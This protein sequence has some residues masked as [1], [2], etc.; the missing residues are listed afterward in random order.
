MKRYI[1]ALLMLTGILSSC[2]SNATK[3]DITNAKAPFYPYRIKDK[4]GFCTAN[5]AIVIPCKYD[6]VF[7]TQKYYM[8]IRGNRYTL[9][10]T[11]AKP[12]D[13]AAMV[14]LLPGNEL[15]AVAA[16]KQKEM[17]SQQQSHFMEIMEATGN[18]DYIRPAKARVLDSNYHSE[19]LAD[20]VIALHKYFKGILWVRNGN[21]QGIYDVSHRKYLVPV[22]QAKIRMAGDYFVVKHS[23]ANADIIDLQG[24]KI[25]LPLDA[26][27]AVDIEPNPLQYAIRKDNKNM[28]YDSTGKL[29]VQDE[30]AT[31]VVIGNKGTTSKIGYRRYNNV[32]IAGDILSQNNRLEFY[33]NSGK[34]KLSGVEE[35]E[36]FYDKYFI[37]HHRDSARRLDDSYVYDAVT[38]KKVFDIFK[39]GNELNKEYVV[40]KDHDAANRRTNVYSYKGD[41]LMTMSDTATYHG[42]YP[43]ELIYHLSAVHRSEDGNFS[44]NYTALRPDKQ[45]HFTVYDDDFNIVSK[46]LDAINEMQMGNSYTLRVKRNGKWGVLDE[47]DFHELIPAV[48]DSIQWNTQRYVHVW[49]DGKA[50]WVD[51]ANNVLFNGKDFDAIDPDGVGGHWLAMKLILQKQNFGTAYRK[52]EV[53]RAYIIDANGKE[54]A[55]W[56]GSA[57]KGYEYK[58]TGKGNI[59][60]YGHDDYKKRIQVQVLDAATGETHTLS[61]V[62]NNVDLC[63]GVA[64]VIECSNGKGAGVVSADDLQPLVPF[65]PDIF[66]MSRPA[67]FLDGMKQGILL[68]EVYGN[69]EETLIGFYSKDGVAYWKE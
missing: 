24:N 17:M 50:F 45:H 23:D 6:H 56:E 59:L 69:N 64:L 58:L 2:N 3:I 14:Y 21:K 34:L 51:T 27:D 31:P 52:P 19:L 5:K 53:A 60:R 16:T 62:L 65:K 15:L 41:L 11:H 40:F 28:I 54:I 38:G 48:Y 1:T 42:V 61:S 22:Q 33:D 68:S 25:N 39:N 18:W 44:K 47:Y 10:D 63:N 49:K 36:N 29:I 35:M 30:N 26:A 55:N 46:D 4:W 37:V 20:S 67:I 8:G 32:P 13:S 12:V 57:D 66:Y 43:E 7:F 9:Y